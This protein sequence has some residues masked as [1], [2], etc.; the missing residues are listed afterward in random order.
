MAVDFLGALGAGSDI[1]TKSLVQSLVDAEKLPRE[2]ALNKKLDKAELEI[3]AYGEV[4]AELGILQGA[5]EELN[6]VRD[7]ADYSVSVAGNLTADGAQAFTVS[8]DSSVAQGIYNVRVTSLASP[9]RWVSAGFAAANTAINGG[10]P[11]N[12]TYTPS[13]GSQTVITIADPTPENLVTAINDSDL[14]LEAKLVDSGKDPNR[15][16]VSIT[17]PSGSENDFSLTSDDSIG[18]L[19]NI[20]RSQSASDSSLV[21][22]GVAIERSSNSID[23]VID[24]L[25]LNLAGISQS[26]A[27]I[28]VNRDVSATKSK[29]SNLVTAFNSVFDKFSVLRDPD[30]DEQYGGVFSGNATIRLIGDQIKRLAT[31]T[32]STPSDSIARLSDLGI[33]LTRDGRLEVDEDVL[34]TALDDDFQS[35]IQMFS[36]NTD[37]QSTFGEADRGLAGDAIV[38]LNDLMASDGTILTQTTTLEAKTA[39]YGDALA[40]LDLRMQKIYDRYLA[41]FTAMETAIDEINSTKDYLKS[42][43]E[44]LPFTAKNN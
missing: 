25:T 27:T 10:N 20:S 1:D 6:D 3:S 36:A 28:V 16:V 43:L 26:D 29:V 2:T 9:A 18:S 31:D 4:L 12:L 35:V 21:V 32:S 30:S 42:T 14:N 37:N 24:G 7:F 44:N 38:F 22:D 8:G 34:Q 11:F 17:G 19:L 33:T 40:D 13:A 41:Q 15:F 39:D 5:F 23:D